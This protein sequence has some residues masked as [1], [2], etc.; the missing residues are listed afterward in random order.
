[1][2]S[3]REVR[4]QQRRWAEAGGLTA[5]YRGYLDNVEL[6]LRAPLS[7]RAHAAFTR[8]SG[9]ELLAHGARPSKM[10]ALHSSAALAVNVFDHWTDRDPAAIQRA[11]GIDSQIVSIAFEEKFETG[12]PGSPPNLDVA[13][14]LASGAVVGI[15][16]KFTEWLTRKRASRRPFKEKY[17]E[18]GVEPWAERGLHGCQGLVNAMRAG[19]AVF[20]HLDA[21]Q[22]LKHALGLATQRPGR[23]GLRY[24]FLDISCPSSARH[25]EELERFAERVDDALAFRGESYQTLIARLGAEATVDAGYVC[26]LRSRYCA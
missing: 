21:A 4:R 18:G 22:L 13:L 26:Y 19:E 12:L 15:E 24:L 10:C 11:L 23:C 1:M 20:R 3:K 8:G 14:E 6:N 9:A 2:T 16:S 7:R 17:F 5:D 25:R